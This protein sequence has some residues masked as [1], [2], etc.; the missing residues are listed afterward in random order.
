[1]HIEDLSREQL[2]AV[3]RAYLE[4]LNYGFDDAPYG[5]AEDADK[6]ISDEEIIEYHA[7]TE[8]V[9]EDFIIAYI[10]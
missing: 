9:P 3:K 8:F 6:V 10:G 5:D 1:M 4:W 2:I 7:V